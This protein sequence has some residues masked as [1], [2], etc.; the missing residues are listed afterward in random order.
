MRN[1]LPQQEGRV[2]WLFGRL[3][4]LIAITAAFFGGPEFYYRTLPFVQ[5]F[6]ETRYGEGFEGGVQFVWF[7]LTFGITFF[8]S[9]I[10]IELGLIILFSTAALRFLAL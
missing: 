4:D 7:V 5:R 9:R 3:G 2:S 8:A 1:H 6:A 10:V